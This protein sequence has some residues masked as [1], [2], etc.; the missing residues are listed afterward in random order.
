MVS[1]KNLPCIASE[2]LPLVPSEISFEISLE[3]ILE[4][5]SDISSRI[6]VEHFSAIPS[7]N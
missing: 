1:L 3:F 5:A 6:L 2:I 7:R 4:I